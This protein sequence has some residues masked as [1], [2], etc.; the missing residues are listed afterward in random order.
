[1]TTTDTFIVSKAGYKYIAIAVGAIVLFTFL[2]LAFLRLLSVIVLGLLIYIYRNPEQEILHM[3]K[4]ALLSPVDGKITA[5]HTLDNGYEIVIK[6]S[7]FDI[8]ILRTPFF[9]NVHSVN[10]RRGARLSTDIK[11]SALLNEKVD[12][13]FEDRY[14]NVVHVEHMLDNSID[15]L[16]IYVHD[17][18]DL[19]QGKRYGVMTKGKT[20]ISVPLS[21]RLSIQ[22]DSQVKAGETLLGYLS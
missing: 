7:L 21:S 3:Q 18:L 6:S 10:L 22:V 5:I 2:D 14:N 4:G 16:N 1:M 8:S 12:M 11:K 20:V 17:G 19:S 9:S 15:D 13:I